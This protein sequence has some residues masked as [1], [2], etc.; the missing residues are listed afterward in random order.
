MI[1]SRCKLKEG[2]TLISE[3]TIEKN[4]LLDSSE[5]MKIFKYTRYFF[6][7]EGFQ[8][9]SSSYISLFLIYLNIMIFIIFSQFRRRAALHNEI[10]KLSNFNQISNYNHA[11]INNS[12]SY[13]NG[14]NIKMD[15]III[16]EIILT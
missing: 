15:I 5:S 1:N 6:S 4:L 2:I 8:N 16:M 3:I 11:V 14:Y 10:D 9:N 7:K 13:N 12:I